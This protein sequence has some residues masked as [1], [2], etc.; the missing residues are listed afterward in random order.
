MLLLCISFF[1]FSQDSSPQVVSMDILNSSTSKF[2]ISVEFA[3]ALSSLNLT[4]L[5]RCYSLISFVRMKQMI[6]KGALLGAVG[7]THTIAF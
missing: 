5:H 7:N 2:V 4:S 6:R 1:P 3:N